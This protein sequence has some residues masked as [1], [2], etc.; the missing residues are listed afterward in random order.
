M[1]SEDEGIKAKYLIRDNDGKFG[2]VFDHTAESVGLEVV[3]ITPMVPD[4]NSFS[5]AFIGSSRRECLNHFVFFGLSQLDRV[6]AAWQ[7]HYHNE[8]PH[9]GRGIDN[10][11][12]DTSFV[13]QAVG[14]IECQRTLGGLFKSYCRVA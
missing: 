12:L 2:K 6:T 7:K 3:K 10:N 11:V 13:P 8:R 14:K 5:E 1:W 4:M 9:Q